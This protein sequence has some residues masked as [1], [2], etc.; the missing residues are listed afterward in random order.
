MQLDNIPYNEKAE[1]QIIGALMVKP[2]L[3][4]TVIGEIIQEEYF[5]LAQHRAIFKVIVKMIEADTPVDM[6]SL[7]AALETAGDLDNAGGSSYLSDCLAVTT[8]TANIEH[9][10][11]IVIG[12]AKQREILQV[13]Q[14][15][16]VQ[17]SGA[18]IDVDE[19]VDQALTRLHE[20]GVFGVDNTNPRKLSEV[21]PEIMS[22]IDVHQRG[23]AVEIGVPTGY[24]SL[25]YDIGSFLPGQLIIIAARP[26]AGK[27]ALALN[28]ARNIS[29]SRKR[30]L[31]LSLEMTERELAMRLLSCE[32]EVDLSPLKRKKERL[33][34]EALRKLAGG[35]TRLNDIPLWVDDN[36]D[37]GLSNIRSQLHRAQIQ[38]V[39]ADV[40]VVDYLQLMRLGKG[41]T[42]DV[43]LGNISRGL[44][45][46]AKSFNIP[47]IVLS[48]LSRANVRDAI[49]A[50]VLSDLRGSGSLEQDADIVIFI[51]RPEEYDK[52]RHDIKNLAEV[53][54]AKNRGGGI[55]MKKFT[56]LRP[57]QRFEMRSETTESD[58][59]F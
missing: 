42:Q 45:I 35:L 26:G 50:P 7:H 16:S 27:S 44:K 5:W 47:V 36:A 22:D 46:I 1:Q 2:D 57:I 14:W 38:H 48:Q 52:E 12:I 55:G 51:H 4:A 6:V 28:I 24:N 39:P 23:E 25:D 13:A 43:R 58:A 53:N 32:S 30:V 29:L 34:T 56:F 19:V 11:E 54:I 15:L 59:G 18:S 10:C 37:V 17:A 41:E 31:F 9:H 33:T 20:I 3:Y 21:L 8:S 40:L 49:R